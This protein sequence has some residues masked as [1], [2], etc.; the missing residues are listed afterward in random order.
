MAQDVK[1]QQINSLFA[2]NPTTTTAVENQL[3]ELQLSE[4]DKTSLLINLPP[5]FPEEPPVITFSPT[6][7]RHPLL[8]T[9]VVLHDS[10]LN[11]KPQQSI[12]G[13]VVKEIY[14]EFITRPPV[15][16]AV[17]ETARTEEGYGYRPPPPI[18]AAS[19]P[20]HAAVVKLSQEEVEELLYNETAF[21]LYFQN[22]ERVK[23]L[24]AFQEEL[25]NGNEI[26]AHKN[27]SREDQLTK[28]R[29]E[30]TYLDEKYKADKLEF[31]AK[32]KL[33]QEA[34]NRFS[35]AT[36][37]TRLKAS[38]YESD[39]LSESVAQSFL[40]GNLNNES[41]VKQFREFRKVYHLRASKLEKAQKDN[42]FVP[43][44]N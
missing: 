15:K 32:E 20:E 12:L 27:L 28:L 16:K 3:Y 21:D 44:Y 18:P 19:N 8:E 5:Q 4:K 26:L 6:H 29:G 43:S 25:R 30:I 37:L 13:L 1:T 36:V 39:E 14:H 2:H 17:N 31:D 11:W 22:M 24:K 38:V 35:S 41:F 10:L 9:D 23:N 33:Q 34:F 40:D 42:L 7:M